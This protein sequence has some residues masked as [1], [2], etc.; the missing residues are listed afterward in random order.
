MS[1]LCCP[2]NCAF[3]VSWGLHWGGLGIADLHKAWL[4]C[5]EAW[6][7]GGA[8]KTPKAQTRTKA[9][10]WLVAVEHVLQQYT[11]HGLA[12]YVS[13]GSS[14]QNQSSLPATGSKPETD[15]PYAR[16]WLGIAWDRGPDSWAGKQYLKYA[17]QA[18]VEES[19]D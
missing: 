14:Q 19:L 17:L 3:L 10:Q 12:R 13:S 2:D 1:F 5:S 7:E 15:D 16:P 6:T 8:I 4:R 18:H 9:D 11:G